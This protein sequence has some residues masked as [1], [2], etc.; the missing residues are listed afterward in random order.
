MRVYLPA[1]LTA[2]ACVLRTGAIGPAPVRGFA[3]T[4][5]LREWYAAGDLD[6][7]E[8]VAMA[9]AA[10]ALLLDQPDD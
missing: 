10:R 7:L 6:E 9:H 2:L 1:T 3:V 4:P 5:A 8:Y